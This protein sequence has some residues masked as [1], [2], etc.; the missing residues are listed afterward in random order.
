MSQRDQKTHEKSWARRE[1]PAPQEEDYD[2]YLFWPSLSNQDV[3]SRDTPSSPLYGPISIHSE[4][5]D[6]DSSVL[7][8]GPPSP[9]MF[10]PALDS[11][12]PLPVEETVDFGASPA[13][14]PKEPNAVP[15]ARNENAPAKYSTIFKMGLFFSQMTHLFDHAIEGVKLKL[16]KPKASAL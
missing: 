7:G 10:A 12:F 13:S 16:R 8:S 3:S 14:P 6:Y 2:L 9:I 11:R 5:T 1:K 4:S 15:Q